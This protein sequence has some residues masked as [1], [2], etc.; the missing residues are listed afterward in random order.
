MANL[1]QK[2]RE[3]MLAFLKQLK[4]EH[5]DDNCVLFALGEI[6]SELTAKN[7]A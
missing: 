1:S 4:E 5:K 3:R 2:K 7:T 6:E